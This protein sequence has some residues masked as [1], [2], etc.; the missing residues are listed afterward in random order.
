MI[1]VI[2]CIWRGWKEKLVSGLSDHMAV[3]SS[4]L[5]KAC[6]PEMTETIMCSM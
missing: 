4:F 1:F 3:V 5:P 6:I 2:S